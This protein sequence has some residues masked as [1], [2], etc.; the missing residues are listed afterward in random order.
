M[1]M[2]AVQSYSAQDYDIRPSRG[3]DETNKIWYPFMLELG[4]D[5]GPADLATYLDHSQSRGMLLA[6]PQGSSQPIGHVAAIIND[7]ATGWV[8]LFIVDKLYQGIGLGAALWTEMMKE[9][10]H[11][12]TQYVGLD[13]VPQQKATYERRRFVDS[14]L[15]QISLM[16]RPFHVAIRKSPHVVDSILEIAKVSAH[17]L[18]EFELKYTGFC[19]PG[20]WRNLL[21]RSDVVGYAVVSQTPKSVGD[22]HACAF[23]RRCPSGA[24]L[25]P[26][27][28]NTV[29]TAETVL[30]HTLS[31]CTAEYMQS[32][33]MKGV[34]MSNWS[35]DDIHKQ[36]RVVAEIWSGNV[37]AVALFEK[38]GWTS[39]GHY[40]RMW[41]H[42]RA[43]AA[44]GPGGLAQT[45][46]FATFDAATG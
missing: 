32:F 7:N 10:E 35:S 3:H 46:V 40:H 6:F 31:A 19:R 14:E 16:T 21:S 20:M 44:Q 37:E 15:G 23:V 36:A 42:G 33:P 34:E 26:L 11:C 30:S 13:A 43:P 8:A 29:H 24:R 25:G 41:L 9:F 5:R 18:A 38:V 27:Y 1:A 39:Q 22:I 12:N 4:W 45:G 28:A 2:K 17:L